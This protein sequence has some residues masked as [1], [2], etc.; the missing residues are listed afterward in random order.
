MS[1][2]LTQH[3]DSD[4][5]EHKDKSL[6]EQ[7]LDCIKQ[8]E[9]NNQK[10]H[11]EQQQNIDQVDT[12]LNNSDNVEIGEKLIS[13]LYKV[14]DSGDHISHDKYEPIKTRISPPDQ[15]ND[16]QSNIETSVNGNSISTDSGVNG[17]S[18]QINKLEKEKSGS[19]EKM[20]ESVAETGKVKDETPSM[21][22]VNNLSPDDLKEGDVEDKCFKKKEQAEGSVEN[23]EQDEWLDILGS[24]CL[25]RKVLQKGN[26]IKPVHG[27]VVTVASEG[28][29]VDG[30]VV[31]KE[32]SF[33]FTLGDGD[34]I[35]A[36]DLGVSIMEVGEIIELITDA[37]FAYGS[38]GREPDIPKDATITYTLELLKKDYP[39]D[40]SKLTLEEIM[41]AGEKKRERGNYYF[42]R[43]DHSSAMT[44]YN[45]ALKIL[46]LENFSD[47]SS[48][49]ISRLQQV[50]DS[51]V[52]CYNNL[53][54]CQLKV[55]AYDMVIKS[56]QEVLNIQSENVKAL[57]RMGKA[58]S[59]KGNT[60]EA[61]DLMKKALRLEPETKIIHQELS[62][63]TKKLKV[64]T[65]SE[66]NMYKKMLGTKTN[67]QK[68]KPQANSMKWIGIAGAVTAVLVSVGLAA[69]K[70]G[71]S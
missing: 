22:N 15:A 26:G 30:T 20:N 35:P 48:S 55:E 8:L 62:K 13:D 7:D 32:E 69:Y 37:R 42:T 14:T 34:V 40:Y 36:W 23:E 31:D 16:I 4:H 41:K 27:D 57:F 68:Q 6:K 28:R 47:V 46:D 56:C 52:K 5:I 49:D 65:Q 25:K 64:E 33:T 66:K 54:A 51:R 2:P 60:K 1:S 11:R 12:D 17:E 9:D 50:L 39:I 45:K 70:F 61:V 24:G 44:S 18:N 67:V 3:K 43:L 53:A 21:L 71:H 38:I 59:A 58:Y 29:L 63:L 19:T 10:E